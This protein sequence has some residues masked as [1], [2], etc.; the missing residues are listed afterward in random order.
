MSSVLEAIN[1]FFKVTNDALD[2]VL[3]WVL[4]AVL[5]VYP[6]LFLIRGFR[7]VRKET[8][9]EE[10]KNKAYDLYSGTLILL[11]SV[12]GIFV[13]FWFLPYIL[14]TRTGY[15][16]LAVTL[17]WILF[18]LAG[19]GVA[20]L[21]GHRNGG[22][23]WL[24]TA[25][26]H[27][28]VIFIGWIIQHWVGIFL[29]SV[30]LLTAYYCA[31]FNLA[32]VVLPASDPENVSEKWK[33]F[34]LLI[35]YTWGVQRDLIVVGDHAWKKLETRIP[36]D[37][38]N[39]FNAPGL[40]WTRSHQAVGIT[41][42]SKFKKVDGPG[43]I[44]TGNLERPLQVMDLRTQVRSSEIDVVSKDGV[45]FKAFVIVAFRLDPEP[46]DQKTYSILRRMNPALHEAD[47]LS[48]TTGSFP[49]SQQRVQAAISMTRSQADGDGFI[50][51]DQWA[52]GV[53]EQEARQ[54]ISQK[55]LNELWRPQ[56][57]KAGA[58]A[59]SKI[60][61][62]L[63]DKV[64]LTLRSAG[65]LVDVARVVNFRFATGINQLDKISEQ[66]ISS[67][68]SEWE[69]KRA[70]I[71]AE[72][73]AESERTQHEAR[74]YAE[75]LL[76]TA[77]AEGLQRTEQIDPNLPQYVISMRFLSVFQDF[78]RQQTKGED[79]SEEGK[80]PRIVELQARLKDMQYRFFPGSGK[81]K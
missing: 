37:V 32:Q 29:I 13:V 73:E 31:L 62:E 60:A 57:D 44:F 9:A 4:L 58:N 43:L 22:G 67:W 15:D 68:G 69:R 41:S 26:G 72:A 63:K 18:V 42:G 6:I 48:H 53:I 20:R 16:W 23:R 71:L 61:D 76:L 36:G 70:N 7:R 28:L 47:K 27:I 65:I 56:N 30:P 34:F 77:I 55:E 49:F 3:P 2:V 11:I 74:A 50:Y 8:R 79:A 35:A 17:R 21:Y 12:I 81:E 14:F 1:W 5:L 66:Q 19:I 45:K 38:S 10:K 51:W 54:V 40:I 25:V 24:P 52:L 59:L 80:D 46:W 75:S 64:S 33:K 78:V 39:I